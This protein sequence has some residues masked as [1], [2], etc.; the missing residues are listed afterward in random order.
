M[1]LAAPQ[2]VDMCVSGLAEGLPALYS[3]ARL[4]KMVSCGV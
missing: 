1:W 3:K 2:L 4:R